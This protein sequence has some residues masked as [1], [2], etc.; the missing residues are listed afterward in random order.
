MYT[1]I[2]IYIYTHI[3]WAT[4]SPPAPPEARRRPRG[5]RKGTNGV[6]TN[7]VA[8]FVL[9]FDRGILCFLYLFRNLSKLITFPA[10]LI[11]SADP[12][13]PQPR[14]L[15]RLLGFAVALEHG[16]AI[17]LPTD[18]RTQALNCSYCCCLIITVIMIIYH[19]D[20]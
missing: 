20:Y 10:A 2:Y 3:R 7:G 8:A 4:P 17:A 19:Y 15:E 12:M 18:A 13:C 6:G 9:F 5:C 16:G 11:I 14:L 1:Y